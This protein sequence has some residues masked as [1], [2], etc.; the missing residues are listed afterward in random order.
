MKILK[1]SYLA[2]S[3]AAAL[4]SSAA[5]AVGPGTT[6]DFVFYYGGGS[7]EPQAVA[8]A[9][10]RLMSNVD[11]Y[12][13]TPA[14]KPDTKYYV[15]YGTTTAAHGS[16]PQALLLWNGGANPGYADSVLARMTHYAAP[17]R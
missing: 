17:A 11:L 6:P 5:Y 7:A 13:S 2:C 9:T 14:G 16:V 15:L 10:C 3:I 4:G 12:T 1:A 8:V